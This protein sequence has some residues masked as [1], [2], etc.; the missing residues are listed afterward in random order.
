[1][2]GTP[3][4]IVFARHGE[5]QFNVEG[6]WQGQSDS[7]LTERGLAQ[8]RQLA[9]ALSNEP[10]AAVYSSDLGRAARTADEVAKPHQLAV[11]TDAR[12]REIDVGD[13][14]GRNRAQIE[15]FDADGLHT[16]ASMPA[17]MR[18]P[19]GESLAEAQRRALAFFTYAMPAHAGETVAV[20]THG[21]V[22]QAILVAAMGRTVDDLWLKERLDNCQISR[23]EWTPER[24]L[25][26]VEL[27]DVRHLSE[28]G[29]L[30]NWRITDKD[31]A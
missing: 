15:Q 25:Q 31:V 13:W 4:R 28:V 30:R 22:G 20:V 27:S 18:L 14:T 2:G 7:P 29:S 17:S 19:N 11:T 9:L 26:L 16:W 5:T 23:L 10:L 8:A 12:L 1:M 6:R 21:A 3:V 24:G